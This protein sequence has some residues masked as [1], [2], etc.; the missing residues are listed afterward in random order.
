MSAHLP[1]EG[2]KRLEIIP[3]P[4]SQIK[5]E[6]SGPRKTS[7]VFC[8]PRKTAS[9]KGDK[10]PRKGHI[11]DA[12]SVSSVSAVTDSEMSDSMSVISDASDLS[13]ISSVKKLSLFALDD[14]HFTA[15]RTTHII[16]QVH[17][18]VHHHGAR[19]KETRRIALDLVPSQPKYNQKELARLQEENFQLR[20][21]NVNLRGQVESFQQYQK[22]LIP[23]QSPAV[24]FKQHQQL[25]H[26]DQGLR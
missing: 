21:Q 9:H 2:P 11:H 15:A 1:V 25:S 24:T 3:Y 13:V 17:G 14:I 23:V 20:R 22:S 4:A 26:E 7:S 16:P 8:A 19:R 12:S 18:E 5:V 6:K 10:S